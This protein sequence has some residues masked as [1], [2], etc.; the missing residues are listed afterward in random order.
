[1]ESQQTEKVE[2]NTPWAFPSSCAFVQ[3]PENRLFVAG[4]TGAGEDGAKRMFEIY[5]SQDG[6]LQSDLK[7]EMHWNRIDFSICSMGSNML[8]ATGSY[9]H[10]DKDEP[11]FSCEGYNVQLNMWTKFPPLN[12]GRCF[13]S[14]CGF[15]GKYIYVMCGLTR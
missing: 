11:H 12:I 5:Q 10:N 6:S 8:V 3:T 9:L 13:H 2:A 14:S 4:G 15:N 7:E 1:M